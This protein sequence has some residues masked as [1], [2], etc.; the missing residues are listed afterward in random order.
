MGSGHPGKSLVAIHVGF[1]RTSGTDPP[2]DA[3][4]PGGPIASRRRFADTALCEIR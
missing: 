3:I 2:R 4:G 1:L